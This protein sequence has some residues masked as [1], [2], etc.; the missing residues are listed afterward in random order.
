MTQIN[1]QSAGIYYTVSVEMSSC[2]CAIAAGRLRPARCVV[3][4]P[5]RRLELRS[6]SRAS[7]WTFRGGNLVM[8]M[9]SVATTMG[10]SDIGQAT[11]RCDLRGVAPARQGQAGF[12]SVLACVDGS[13]HSA[14]VLDWATAISRSLNAQLRTLHVIDKSANQSAPQDPLAW[15]LRRREVQRRLQTLLEHAG[16]DDAVL[17]VAVGPFHDR[18]QTCLADSL[19]D[20]CVIGAVGQGT[21]PDGVIGGTARR[22]VETSPCSV[23]IVP[24]RGPDDAGRGAATIRR[25]MV[26]LDCSRRAETALPAAVAL[27]DACG[28]EI[29]VI[30]AVPEPAITE[31]GPPD[32]A[33]IALIRN[34]TDRNRKVAERYMS[35]LRARLALDRRAI[36]VLIVSDAEPRHKL[37]WAAKDEAADLIVLSAKGSGGYADQALGSVADFLVTHLGKPLLIV[38]PGPDR[39]TAAAAN[40]GP[41]EPVEKPTRGRA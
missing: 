24:P 37:V 28:A 20:L 35:R 36:R 6:K 21:Q 10:H 32:E 26:P 19:V 2:G 14:A 16:A 33:D 41:G 38:R 30:H 5:T 27:A 9:T 23:L 31:I 13:L 29:V 7:P 8:V 18:L 22:I 11:E 4:M 39:K 17:E 40:R 25:L 3:D 15:E 34:V 1:S 12:S